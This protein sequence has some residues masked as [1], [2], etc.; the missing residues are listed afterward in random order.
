MV[1]IYTEEASKMLGEQET[2][3]KEGQSEIL[4][5]ISSV[6]ENVHN[7]WSKVGEFCPSSVESGLCCLLVCVSL[8]LRF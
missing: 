7:I 6:K 1:G 3:R 5:D 8:I 2:S 4:E